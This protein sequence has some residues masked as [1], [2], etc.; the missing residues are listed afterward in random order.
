MNFYEKRY[1]HKYLNRIVHTTLNPDIQVLLECIW[2]HQNFHYLNQ[3]Q[4]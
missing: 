1:E 2:F 3:D 4:V